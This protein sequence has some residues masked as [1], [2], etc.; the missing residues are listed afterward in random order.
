MHIEKKYAI[1]WTVEHAFNPTTYNNIY[2]DWSFIAYIHGFAMHHRL[3]N[4][5]NA[6]MENNQKLWRILWFTE[7]HYVASRR[8]EWMCNKINDIS[9]PLCMTFVD[10]T[11]MYWSSLHKAWSIQDHCHQL[12]RQTNTILSHRWSNTQFVRIYQSLT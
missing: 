11:A 4:C 12:Q 9:F 10:I 2:I 5:Q 1:N 6:K 7:K 3:F 8:K